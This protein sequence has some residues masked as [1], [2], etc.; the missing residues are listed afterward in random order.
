[1]LLALKMQA[2]D[3][4]QAMQVASM[5]G[6]GKEAD[7]PWSPQKEHSSSDLDFSPVR[8]ISDF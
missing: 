5:A 8:L 2:G 1:M 4:G 3:T 7:S 6:K